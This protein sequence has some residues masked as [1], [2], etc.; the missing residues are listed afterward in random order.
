MAFFKWLQQQ[1]DQLKVA[2]FAIL[3]LTMFGFGMIL[4]S[5]LGSWVHTQ[6]SW[7]IPLLTFGT[8]WLAW[9]FLRTPQIQEQ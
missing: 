8:A 3:K 2:D 6:W 1:S 4:G 9:R 5:Y 7:L